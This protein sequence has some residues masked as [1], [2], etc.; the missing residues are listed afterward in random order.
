MM[1]KMNEEYNGLF[2]KER[3]VHEYE[4]GTPCVAKFSDDKRW[5]RGEISKV[6]GDKVTVH[7]VDYG[8][9]ETVDKSAVKAANANYMSL[10][11]QGVRC[12]L[13]GVVSEDWSSKAIEK[14][15]EL[16]M[17]KELLADVV[18]FSGGVYLVKLSENSEDV[19]QQLASTG[20]CKLSSTTVTKPSEN[21]Y[22]QMPQE[23]GKDIT[24]YVSWIENPHSFWIQPEEKA[25]TLENLVGELQEHYAAGGDRMDNVK[26]GDAVIAKFSEDEAWYRAFVENI[27][28]SD[29]TVRFVDYG[30]TDKVSKS[31]LFKV[32]ENFLQ[33]PAQALRC[34]LSGVKP[35]QSG[36]SAD[37]KDIMQSL[38]PEAVKVKFESKNPDGTWVVSLSA[39]DVDVAEELIKTAV[40]RREVSSTSSA[41]EITSQFPQQTPLQ[42]GSTHQVFVS[43]VNSPASFY[44]QLVQNSEKLDTLLGD[45]EEQAQMFDP[46][47]SLSEG[48]ACMAKYS[49]DEAWYRSVITRMSGN[50]ADV[51]FVDYGNSEL[52]SKDDICNIPPGLF[53]QEA[54]AIHCRL[55]N[56]DG[57]GDSFED[58]VADKEMTIK[59]VSP[60]PSCFTV[61]LFFEDGKPLLE[62]ASSTCESSSLESPVYEHVDYAE[63]PGTQFKCFATYIK[64]PFRIYLQKDGCE[65]SLESMT[66]NL[67]EVMG[68]CSGL[69]NPRL[70]QICGTVFSE[71]KAWYRGVIEEVNAGKA[72]IRFIDYG[73]SEEAEIG[74]LKVL[75]SELAVLPPFAYPCSLHGVSPLEG[76]WSSE[77]M[78]QLE[79]L[80]VEKELTCTFVTGTDVKLEV[81]DKDVGKSLQEAGL[82]KYEE[83]SIASEDIQPVRV[84]SLEK[85]VVPTEPVTAYVSHTDKEKFYLQLSSQEEELGEMIEKIQVH[86]DKSRP[87]SEVSL[88]DYCC[89]KFTTDNS[90]YRAHVKDTRGDTV[91]VLF[92]DFG[93]SDSLTKDNLR[94][95]G[96]DCPALAYHC[97][98]SGCTSMSTQ[99][100]ELFSKLTLD[101]E[102]TATFDQDV[103]DKY[104]VTLLLADGMNV[105]KEIIQSDGQGISTSHSTDLSEMEERQDAASQSVI[106]DESHVTL[107][108]TGFSEADLNVTNDAP[109]EATVTSVGDLKLVGVSEEGRVEVSVSCVYSPSCFYI[110]QGDTTPLNNLLDQMFEFYSNA[111]ACSYKLDRVDINAPCAARF[112]DDAT[113][114]RA[115]IKKQV[116]VD[117]V[118]VMFL[119]HGNVEVCAIADLRRLLSRFSELPLQAVECSLAGVR[120][121]DGPWSSEAITLFSNLTKDKNLLADIVSIGDDSSCIVQLLHMGLSISERLLEEGH[122]IQA[123]TP[124]TISKKVKRVFSDSSDVATPSLK[125]SEECP[126]VKEEQTILYGR[127]QPLAVEADTEYVV[128][129]S[130]SEHPE[131]F[132][133][134]LTDNVHSLSDLMDEMLQEYSKNQRPVKED[135]TE[136]SESEAKTV[137]DESEGPEQLDD[138]TPGTSCCVHFPVDG[139]YYRSVIQELLNDDNIKVF[140]VD[141]GNIEVVN[142]CHI[143]E[144]SD[145]YCQMPAQAVHCRLG[146]IATQ[147]WDTSSC[148]R[149]EELTD[150]KELLL[151]VIE[152]MEDGPNIVELS[153]GETS[154]TSCLIEGGYAQSDRSLEDQAI[155]LVSLF[156]PYTWTLLSLDMEYDI[157]V[158]AVES[159]V[160]FFVMLSD[161]NEM[162][163]VQEGINNYVEG[164]PQEM[165]SIVENTPCLVLNPK[166]KEYQRAKCVKV[167]SEKQIQVLL[168]DSGEKLTTKIDKLFNIPDSLLQIPAQVTVCAL[169]DIFS[170]IG[171][172]SKEA[173]LFFSDHAEFVSIM[174]VRHKTDCELYKVTLDFEGQE[175]NRLLVD[176][177][178]AR[179][180][181]DTT[182]FEQML[183]DSSNLET[184]FNELALER[185]NSFGSE[186]DGDKVQSL[187]L[188]STLETTDASICMCHDSTLETTGAS[189]SFHFINVKKERET[190]KKDEEIKEDEFYD[191]YDEEGKLTPALEKS[192]DDASS[193]T[194]TK[195]ADPTSSPQKDKSLNYTSS[196]TPTKVADSPVSPQK[197]TDVQAEPDQSSQNAEQNKE[198]SDDE[199]LEDGE[200][201]DGLNNNKALE[202]DTTKNLSSEVEPNDAVPEENK[203]TMRE[204]NTAG[205]QR[206]ATEKLQGDIQKDD[207]KDMA[208]V[209]GGET[210]EEVQKETTVKYKEDISEDQ[211]KEKEECDGDTTK[212]QGDVTKDK[213]DSVG[214][215]EDI[216]NNDAVEEESKEVKKD[217][218]DQEGCEEN[219]QGEDE[220]SETGDLSKENGTDCGQNDSA[221]T[222][223]DEKEVNGEEEREDQKDSSVSDSAKINSEGDSSKD[224]HSLK[225]GVKE[226]VREFGDKAKESCDIL[227]SE[228]G[229]GTD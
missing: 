108:E 214:K 46:V 228:A 61:D 213:E 169:T 206:E 57:V 143:Y 154:I 193:D 152:K 201:E 90:W 215:E 127:F 70:G 81:E 45:I 116:D 174:Y 114:Y 33:V 182:L 128:S 192:V 157:K 185:Q 30:N 87:L 17:D 217:G 167:F 176:L 163:K 148:G 21:P 164:N 86:C 106:M 139:Q 8:N 95:L 29:T 99:Q 123:T 68:N 100:Q 122:G 133:C 5:Y 161:C 142:Q 195:E 93:N 82:V 138:C 67:Q 223:S 53:K 219:C 179:A 75:P 10:E 168:I 11:V 210:M 186:E 156:S 65:G 74:S 120:A 202:D 227:A 26:S 208:E 41:S 52:T 197:S 220:G 199:H 146:G 85:Q 189:D 28:G 49:A 229:E 180:E 84:T 60:S 56:P 13:S 151:Y 50:T 166:R 155:D 130:H 145:D 121:K 105:N 141:F 59:V 42:E 119:D 178:Y 72:K 190:N 107:D 39:G 173:K 150:D 24:A 101:A 7:F 153:D 126:I 135:S 137:S 2:P 58:Q 38:V 34:N 103:G 147:S 47:N 6:E 162:S 104:E 207:Q 216:D 63:P 4:T 97:C 113:W 117:K 79:T 198:E 222:D 125:L 158:T 48:M 131:S 129:I 196:D 16:V 32:A 55:N 224:S 205:D 76:E 22:P 144:L 211:R 226:V 80:I 20:L 209:C 35:L 54:Q 19:A 89:A 43:H 1:E 183:D 3:C 172:W 88:G 27:Q 134:H 160:Q 37:T 187:N 44:C 184:S 132:W 221:D 71:D 124:V 15:E 36:W 118:E 109:E 18:Y 9:T 69:M 212:D 175:L 31:E 115:V 200:E 77:V 78:S 94:S 170:P 204:E 165:S 91:D 149:F 40:A 191:A 73:N 111:P 25:E 62:S 110:Q 140:F 171:N 102:V 98:L 177:G 64:S 218:P 159:P 181:A 203:E 51:L 92:I 23:V 112:S 136:S 12:S 194:P 83:C 188:D 14:F 66:A 225:D 96:F